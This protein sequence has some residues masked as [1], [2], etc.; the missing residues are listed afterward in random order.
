MQCFD[1]K[2]RVGKKVLSGTISFS[3]RGF[4]RILEAT[5][6]NV[7]EVMLCKAMERTCR[8]P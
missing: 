2:N 7:K 5:K 6:Q 8:A 3:P 4:V 1:A